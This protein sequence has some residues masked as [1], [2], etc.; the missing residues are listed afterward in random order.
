M[1]ASLKR[2]A[3]RSRLAELRTWII[4]ACEN[5]ASNLWVECVVK[6]IASCSRGLPLA[7]P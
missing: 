1:N 7:M 5:A 2:S 6:M 4:D 3:S